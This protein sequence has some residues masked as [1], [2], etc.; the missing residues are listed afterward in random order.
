MTF[1]LHA[2]PMEPF[3][4]LFSLS[5]D[6]LITRGARRVMADADHG[7]PCRISLQDANAGDEL[8]L[9]NYKHLDSNS[10][11]DAAHAIYVRKDVKQAHPDPGEVPAVLSSRL[12][13]VRGFDEL[14]MMVDA[15]VVEG[16]ELCIK[17]KEM[18]SDPAIS[19]VDIH[20]AKQGCFA[21]KATRC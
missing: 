3:E 4:H 2:L 18:F 7:F 6:E 9:V 11:Y 14:R 17:L 20:N 10:P 19:F 16:T 5:D 21:A 13:S 1:Q 15:D 12:L 8:I